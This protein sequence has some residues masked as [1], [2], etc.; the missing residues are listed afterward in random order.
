VTYIRNKYLAY[1]FPGDTDAAGVKSLG[2]SMYVLLTGA[3]VL[4]GEICLWFC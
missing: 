2:N 3:C 4:N 1:L